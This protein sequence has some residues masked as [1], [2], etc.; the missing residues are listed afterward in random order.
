MRALAS[1]GAV[2]TRSA[3]LATLV[4]LVGCGGSQA[5][6]H[7]PL[8]TDQTPLGTPRGQVVDWHHEHGWCATDAP[9][10]T[11]LIFRPCDRPNRDQMFV[12]LAFADDKLVAAAVNVTAPPPGQTPTGFPAPFTQAR[13]SVFHG[14]PARRQVAI[15]IMNALAVEL[16]SRYGSPTYSSWT[17]RRWQRASETVRLSWTEIVGEY[18]VT[19]VHELPAAISRQD[20]GRPLT[21]R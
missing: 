19:E 16:T 8:V 20:A 13:R 17:E 18:L 10:P 14:E 1:C 11:V 15:D 4:T 5:A 12:L 2:V 3:I 9:R 21:P 7:R 6:L